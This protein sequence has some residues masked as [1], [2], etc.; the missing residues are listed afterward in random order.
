[1]RSIISFF[2]KKIWLIYPC[3]RRDLAVDFRS[4]INPKTYKGL[5]GTTKHKTIIINSVLT[6]KI[7]T[8]KG[9]RFQNVYCSGN[10]ELGKFVSINGPGTR[11]ASKINGVKIGS[12]T[13]IASNVIIQ[14]DYHRFDKISTYLMN[15]NIFNSEVKHDL[16]SKGRIVI[17][18]DVWIGSNSIILSGVRIGRGSIIGAGSVVTKDIP[19]YCIAVGNPAR[20]IKKRFDD[21]TIKLLELS[22]WWKLDE[23]VLIENKDSF[24][25]NVRESDL[26]RLVNISSEKAN[27]E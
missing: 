8:G 11:V 17:E 13:S 12:F 9:C 5:K 20:V 4:L 6:G 23:S 22:K 1:M 27:E 14:E 2:I 21:E 26:R 16:T 7:V 3:F 25:S 18:E 10:L 19:A 24:I 15:K